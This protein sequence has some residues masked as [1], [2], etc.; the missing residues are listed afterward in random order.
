VLS[1]QRRNDALPP[2]LQRRQ[3]TSLVLLHKPAV[4]DH[5]GGE[6]DGKAT[7]GAFFGHVPVQLSDI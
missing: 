3:G 5:V 6:N 2:L 4:T 1:H 7:P